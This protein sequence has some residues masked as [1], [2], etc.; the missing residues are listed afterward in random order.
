MSFGVSIA[1]RT[2]A[3]DKHPRSALH[4]IRYL[5]FDLFALSGGVQWTDDHTLLEA[6]AK[7]QLL[8]FSGELPDELVMDALEEVEALDRKARLSAVE[9]PSD[10]SGAHG[11][12]DIGIVTHNHRV[13]AAQLQR[14]ALDVLRGDLHH[15]LARGSRASEADFGDARIFQ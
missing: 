15:V 7:P 13:A 10:R 3:A 1:F 9:K 11:L 2:L 5:A 4:R 12:V 14:D 6:V 8:H